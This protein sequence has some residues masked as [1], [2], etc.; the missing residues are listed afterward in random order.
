MVVK[1]ALLAEA[2]AVEFVAATMSNG[3]DDG[4]RMRHT[5]SDDEDEQTQ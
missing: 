3:N 5:M 4:R 1:A 2:V